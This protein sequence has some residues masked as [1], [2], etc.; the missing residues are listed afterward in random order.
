MS[1]NPRSLFA[2]AQ[3]AEALLP[4][5]GLHRYVLAR[6]ARLMLVRH[7]MERGYQGTAHSHPHDQLVIV[8]SGRLRVTV[9][10]LEE[11]VGPGDSFVVPGGVMHQ[12]TALEASDV[13]DVFTPQRDDYL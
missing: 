3:N 7:L 8:Q 1:A 13:L 2:F 11:E 10:G 5:P 12:A 9:G 6:G 4:E